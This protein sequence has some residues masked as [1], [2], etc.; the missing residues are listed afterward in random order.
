MPMQLGTGPSS[1]GYPSTQ[2]GFVR[3]LVLS[4]RAFSDWHLTAY[5]HVWE[6]SAEEP[7]IDGDVAKGCRTV[8]LNVGVRRVE[9]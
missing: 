3:V 2:R 5:Q 4:K 8:V 1:S 9:Q 6:D 7:T